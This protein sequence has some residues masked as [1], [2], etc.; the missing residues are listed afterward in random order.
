MAL[1]SV[2]ANSVQTDHD[3]KKVAQMT[4][5]MKT[6]CVGRFLI[7]LPVATEITIRGGFVGGFDVSNTKESDED[8]KNHI[9]SM[10]AEVRGAKNEQGRPSLEWNKAVS[11]NFGEGKVLVFD[12]RRA[13]GLSQGRIIEADVF[14]V[15]GML[16]L[17]DVSVA[18]AAQRQGKGRGEKLGHLFARLRPLAEG[19]IPRE[20][21]FCIGH[22]LIRDPYEN[23]ETESVV[24]FAGLP[25][26]PDVSI[27][28]SSMA[29]TAPSAGLL[30]RNAKAAEREPFYMRLAFT[31][32]SERQRTINGLQGEELALRVREANFTTGYSFQWQMAGKQDDIYAPLLTLELESGTNPVSGGKPVQSTLSEEAMLALWERIA[33]SVR[34]RPTEEARA[35]VQEPTAAPLGTSAVAGDACPQ[36]GWWQCC[37]GGT[38]IGVFGGQ[39][40]FVKVGQHMPQALLLPQQTLWQRLRGVQPSYESKK[41]TFWKLVDKRG[42]ARQPPS[43]VLAQAMNADENSSIPAGS[44]PHGSSQ[45]PIGSIAKTGVACPASGWWRCEESPALDGTRW[46]AAGSLLPAATFRAPVPMRG[47]GHPEYIHRRSAWRLVRHAGANEDGMRL[48]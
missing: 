18:G 11:S 2:L 47:A 45:A 4:D 24:M 1:V 27:V 38:G 15:R 22:S 20:P 25:G 3:R 39:R 9:G 28:L 13:Q 17:S 6:V 42:S 7:D 30:E 40:Q 5:R 41:P 26:H 29:G 35:K 37:D 16:R 48:T 33:G 34:L 19:E 12:K 14:S 10:E 46:F 8:F 23:P 31:N 21:G 32:L 44:M 43:V 36:T